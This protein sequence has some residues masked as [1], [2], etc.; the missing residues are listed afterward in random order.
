MITQICVSAGAV[1]TAVFVMHI[2]GKWTN[3]DTIPRWILAITFLSKQATSAD[4]YRKVQKTIIYFGKQ[5][6]KWIE[7]YQLKKR[8]QI[9]SLQ[10]SFVFEN[11]IATEKSKLLSLLEELRNNMHQKSLDHH[12][13]LLWGKVAG[14]IDIWLMIIFHVINVIS[15]VV[16][17]V[18]GFSCLVI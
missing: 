7:M 11:K 1:I 14:R 17:L 12:N 9:G 15:T 16:F 3:G 13:R 18:V 2:H 8:P 10:A 6:G 5:N 4:Q